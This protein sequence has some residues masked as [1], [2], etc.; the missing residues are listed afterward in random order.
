MFKLAITYYLS[1]SWLC[2]LFETVLQLQR[3][4][5]W[6]SDGNIDT[7]RYFWMLKLSIQKQK[8]REKKCTE[9]LKKKF[10]DVKNVKFLE[11]NIVKII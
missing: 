4:T 3:N 7:Y 8:Y 9:N 6:T 10:V 5:A 1:H 11:Q 2:Y